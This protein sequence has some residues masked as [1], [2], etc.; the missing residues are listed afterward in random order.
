[1]TLSEEI[2]TI[3]GYSREEAMRTGC[4]AI[5]PEHLLLGI[6]RHGSGSTADLFRRFGLDPAK[7]KADVE[8]HVFRKEAIPYS[9]EDEITFTRSALNVGSMALMEAMRSG[10]DVEGIHL[11][12]ALCDN[13]G[14]WCSA[15]LNSSG[16]TLGLLRTIRKKKSTD[17]EKKSALPSSEEINRLLSVFYSDKEI[18]S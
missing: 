13:P 16:I 3:L 8:E 12:C 10:E 15:Y 17:S 5:A 18:F 6:L 4:Y 9:D 2:L 14:D 1:M 7:V 11:L